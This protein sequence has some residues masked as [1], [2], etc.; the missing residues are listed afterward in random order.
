MN[1][2]AAI[3]ALRTWKLCCDVVTGIVLLA[4]L[5]LGILVYTR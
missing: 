2:A 5:I 1:R 3:R 4:C